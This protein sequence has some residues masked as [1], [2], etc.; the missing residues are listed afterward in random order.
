MLDVGLGKLCP[1]AC[2]AGLERAEKLGLGPSLTYLNIYISR[3]CKFLPCF[4]V[5]NHNRD[6]LNTP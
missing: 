5:W 3:L 1:Q 4:S 6:D 2:P